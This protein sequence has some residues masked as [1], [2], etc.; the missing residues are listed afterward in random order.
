MGFTGFGGPLLLI[1]QMREHYVKKTQKMSS[2]EFDQS[3]TLIKA[4]PGPIAFQMAVYL[5]QKFHKVGGGFLAGFGLV[6]PAFVM[7]LMIGY[8]YSDLE[9]VSFVRPVLDGFLFSVT[10][11]ILMSL[12]S[13]VVTHYKFIL[14]IPLVLVNMYLSWFQLVAEPLLLS[15]IHI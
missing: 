10:A 3:F 9:A 15:L 14:F 7:M 8:F 5:G 4:M 1:Q 13:L 11:V 6:L 12:K 2:T